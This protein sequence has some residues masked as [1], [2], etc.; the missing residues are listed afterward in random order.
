M[1][2]DKTTTTTEQTLITLMTECAK[3]GD[4]DTVLLISSMLGKVS[5]KVLR[6]TD[7]AMNAKNYKF[8][9]YAMAPTYDDNDAVCLL[10]C[11]SVPALRLWTMIEHGMKTPYVMFSYDDVSRVTGMSD[12]RTIRRAYDELC[13]MGILHIVVAGTHHRP[14]IYRVSS[15]F[16]RIGAHAQRCSGEDLSLYTG[17]LPDD[18]P[19]RRAFDQL[20]IR[21]LMDAGSIITTRVPVKAVVDDQQ[22]DLQVTRLGV[23]DK[24]IASGEQSAAQPE[25]SSINQNVSGNNKNVK[26]RNYDDQIAG[27][28][29]FDDL[30]VNTHG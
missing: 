25:A 24:K 7:A 27:Q 10:N 2:D 19:I 6:A 21:L 17:K 5:E 1:M 18:T 15:C 29:S 22:I 4:Q 16:A 26:N 30:E 11:L 13:A 14:A 23:V 12:A 8:T 28:M 3:A 9:Y 20:A